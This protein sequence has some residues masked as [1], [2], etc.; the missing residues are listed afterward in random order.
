[1]RLRSICVGQDQSKSA[2]GLKLFTPLRRMRRSKLRRDRSV[3]S[4]RAISSSSCRPDQRALVAR[5][6][7]SSSC[8][9]I[10]HKPI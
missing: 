3:I 1:M 7:K 9:G 5:A 2:M 10:A 4:A 6:R 8:V